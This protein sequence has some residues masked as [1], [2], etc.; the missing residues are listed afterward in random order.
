MRGGRQRHDGGSGTTA[1]LRRAGQAACAP[2]LPSTDTPWQALTMRQAWSTVQLAILHSGSLCTRS[3]T[4]AARS[5][6][7]A[8]A[9]S[10]SRPSGPT[11]WPLSTSQVCEEGAGE[12]GGAAQRPG[13]PSY[14]PGASCKGCRGKA[15]RAAAPA[16]RAR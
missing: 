4:A 6:A 12:A 14:L 15:L 2:Q 16:R 11:I 8:E 9:I 10:R 5:A 1:A 7:Q 13:G 3:E